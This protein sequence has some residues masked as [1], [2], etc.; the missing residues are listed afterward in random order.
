MTVKGKQTVADLKPGDLIS[1]G[2]DSGVAFIAG[3]FRIGGSRIGQVVAPDLRQF[4]PNA[5]C[6]GNRPDKQ[7]VCLYR[8]K[9]VSG[10]GDRPGCRD[11]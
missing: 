10:P 9:M 4:S 11:L 6:T 3:L 1:D 8:R 7:F 5:D 2:N